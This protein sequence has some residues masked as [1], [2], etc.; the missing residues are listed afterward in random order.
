MEGRG[1][2]LRPSQNEKFIIQDWLKDNEAEARKLTGPQLMVRVKADTKISASAATINSIRHYLG[3]MPERAPRK[4][5]EGLAGQAELIQKL[6]GLLEEF[7]SI[8]RG[9]EDL[10]TRVAELESN[11]Q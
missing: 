4:P 1:L 6:D 3:F 10:E 7:A 5:K 8:R 2:R 11:R 9:V